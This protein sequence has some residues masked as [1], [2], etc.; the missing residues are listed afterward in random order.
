MPIRVHDFLEIINRLAPAELAEE[1]DNIG[2]QVGSRSQEAA[3]VLVALNVTDAVLDEAVALKCGIVLTHHP[4]IFPAVTAVSDDTSTGRLVHRASR[5]G[6]TVV[7]AHTNLDSSKGGLADT[8][9]EL[10]ELRHVAPLVGAVE[11]LSKIVVFLPESDLDSVRESLFATGAGVIGDYRHCSY[12]TRGTGTFLP[13]TGA[14]PTVGK[15]GR[16]EQVD[17][18]RLEM[19]FPSARRDDVVAALVASHS[20]EEP[21]YDIYPLENKSRHAGSGRVGELSAEV[22]LKDFAATIAELFGLRGVNYAG[23]PNSMIQKVALVP[24]SGAAFIPIAARMAD[25]LVTGDIKYHQSWQA[26]ELGLSLIDVPHDVSEYLALAN[27]LPRLEKELSPWR[28]KLILST[29]AMGIWRTATAKE[30]TAIP[31]E[32]ENSMHKLHVDGGS[33]GNPGPAGIGVLLSDPGGE[34]VDSLANYIGEATN[35][36]AEYQAMISGLEMALDRG[37]SRLAIFSDSELIVRQLDGQYRVK[38]EG[39]RPYYQQAKSLLSKLGEYELKSIPREANAGAD[40]LV[41]RALD[42][43]GF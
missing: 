27:W 31:D 12:I 37:I 26:G 5:E 39:L 38:N 16:D 8:L 7:S 22:S 34:T 29:A 33:R 1:W 17:E 41:N 35:N 19:V 9:A 6:I 42:D 14:H 13:M 21:A 40:E 10:M 15:V 4:L 18:L 43:A 2:L 30:R 36:V 3:G 11:E 32:E 23:E 28:V 24:G 25:V 20:Y